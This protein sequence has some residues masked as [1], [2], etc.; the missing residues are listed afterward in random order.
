MTASV[1]TAST[2]ATV[3]ATATA[4][5]TAAAAP[6]AAGKTR[7]RFFG[8]N[9]DAEAEKRLPLRTQIV[10]QA[11]CIFISITVVFPVLYIFALAIDPRNLSR[12]D[13]LF[14]PGASLDA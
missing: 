12:P 4:D 10:L 14:P 6:V 11:I 13:S 3:T 8:R 7:R 9:P 5:A 2:A 1:P